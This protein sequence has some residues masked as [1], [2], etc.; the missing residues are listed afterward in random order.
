[1]NKTDT[2]MIKDSSH[3]ADTMQAECLNQVIESATTNIWMWVA[4]VEMVIIVI[5]LLKLYSKSSDKKAELKKK[6]MSEGDIDFN[7]IINSSFNSEALYKKLMRVCH[8]DRFA[9]D[10]EKVAIATDISLRLG[11]NKHDINV[12]KALAEEAKNKLNIDIKY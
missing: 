11:K 7:N 5:L 6:V 9:P 1:M 12:L 3:I 10:D 4:M 2:V 8:P